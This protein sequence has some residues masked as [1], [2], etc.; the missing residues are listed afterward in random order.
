MDNEEIM[1]TMQSFAKRCRRQRG[2]GITE[3]ALVLPI[4]LILMVGV[5]EM[6]HLLYL[7]SSVYAGAR[8]A[9]RYGASVSDDDTPTVRFADCNGIEDA[10]RRIAFLAWPFEDF[11][12]EFDNPDY[13]HLPPKTCAEIAADTR[14]VGLGRDQYNRI[15]VT[16]TASYRPLIPFIEFPAM[17]IQTS[18]GRTVIRNLYF[19]NYTSQQ[20]DPPQ[21]SPEPPTGAC[22]EIRARQIINSNNTVEYTIDNPTDEAVAIQTLTLYWQASP[23]QSLEQLSLFPAG[24]VGPESIWTGPDSSAQTEIPTEIDW[25]P[26]DLAL[27]TLPA[28]STGSVFTAYFSKKP[29]LAPGIT[30]DMFF[31][32]ECPSVND[33]HLS[34]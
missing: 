30:L 33:H 23:N 4:F 18:V 7:Y 9:A 11:E 10:A 26:G 20:I 21:S 16:I 3:F 31:S 14:Q 27:R 15:N 17:P 32:D 2:Q 13:P 12:I 24:G 22:P 8:E 28:Q 25:P 34:E 6:G 19:R 1:N 5:I 29:K